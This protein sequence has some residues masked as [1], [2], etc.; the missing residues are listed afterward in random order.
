VV[1][2]AQALFFVAAV[3]EADTAVRAVLLRD[4]DLA[5]RVAPHQQVLAEEAD[6]LR[7]VVS[8]ELPVVDRR[9]PV[10]AHHLAHRRTGANATKQVV[11]FFT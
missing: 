8:L 2:A 9:D 5:R 3:V 4:A 11:V 6:A 7:L 1:A 10:A